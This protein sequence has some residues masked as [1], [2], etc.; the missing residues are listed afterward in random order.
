PVE[1]VE[2]PENQGTAVF[3]PVDAVRKIFVA[4]PDGSIVPET[5]PTHDVKPAKPT[6]EIQLKW[7][8]I[9][10]QYKGTWKEGDQRFGKISIRLVGDEIRGAWT[11]DRESKE[12]PATPELADLAWVRAKAGG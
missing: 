1:V 2:L 6:G 9:E 4:G 3:A 7:S 5:I 11:T 10:R 8:R 12:N